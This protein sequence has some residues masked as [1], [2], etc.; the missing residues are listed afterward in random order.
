VLADLA[1]AG[2]ALL[3]FGLALWHARREPGGPRRYGIEL[4]GLVE[5]AEV[6]GAEAEGA[7]PGP[8]LLETVR[9]ALPSAVRELGVG[10]GVALLVFPPFVVGFWLWHAPTHPFRWSP[11]PDLLTFALSQIVVVA[12]PEE[13]FFRGYVQSRLAEVWPPARPTL[14]AAV[15]PRVLVMQAALFALVHLA[16]EPRLDKLAT[17]FPGLLFGWLRAKRGGVG[18]AI[19]LHACSNLLADLL[20][21]GWLL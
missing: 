13:A 6:E 11:A 19:V 2:T 20:V 16:A 1:G 3:F 8:G 10:V 9:A 18:A 7:E 5:G 4:G 14:G 17:F 12:L 15:D 21:R